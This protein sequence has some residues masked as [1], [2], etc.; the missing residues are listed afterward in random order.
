MEVALLCNDCFLP[1]PTG[2]G[3]EKIKARP[4]SRY[5]SVATFLFLKQKK[6][7]GAAEMRFL[8]FLLSKSCVWYTSTAPRGIDSTHTASS[9]GTPEKR[10]QYSG[11]LQVNHPVPSEEK[12]K[13][14]LLEK[15]FTLSSW[16][17]SLNCLDFNQLWFAN[18]SQ[19]SCQPHGNGIF[20]SIHRCKIYTYTEKQRH[21]IL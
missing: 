20:K 1:V 3:E 6:G 18:N 14:I 21:C 16:L 5:L 17:I 9:Q 13:H 12:E 7:L 15:S 2:R 19:Q 11:M 10:R 4:F 8:F